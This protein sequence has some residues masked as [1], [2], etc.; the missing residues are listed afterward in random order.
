MILRHKRL[1]KFDFYYKAD[2]QPFA[3]QDKRSEQDL[4]SS[5]LLHCSLLKRRKND[6]ST[7][8]TFSFHGDEIEHHP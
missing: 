4:S 7:S 6:Y 2:T 3:P 5:L 1:Y 8:S